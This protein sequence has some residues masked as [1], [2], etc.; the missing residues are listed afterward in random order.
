MSELGVRNRGVSRFQGG[1]WREEV[2]GAGDGRSL[3]GG[4]R[5]KSDLKGVCG[6]GGVY[7]SLRPAFPFV[8]KLDFY[9]TEA[10]SPKSPNRSPVPSNEEHSGRAALASPTLLRQC[11]SRMMNKPCHLHSHHCSGVLLHRNTLAFSD[12]VGSRRQE[13]NKCKGIQYP[14]TCDLE[15]NLEP[16]MV[17]DLHKDENFQHIDDQHQS[18]SSADVLLD[19]D[20]SHQPE[21]VEVSS[22]NSNG[23][24]HENTQQEEVISQP[25]EEDTEELQR[26]GFRNEYCIFM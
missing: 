18:S 10:L 24:S 23:R 20:A 2:I 6:F 3:E 14:N 19:M 13:H 22:S 16:F 1:R 7:Q 15:L 5:R 12:E 21:Q 17:D 25:E 26:S 11:S 8:C 9:S 4:K